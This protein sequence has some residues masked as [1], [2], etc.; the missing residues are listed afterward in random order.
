LDPQAISFVCQEENILHEEDLQKAM[1]NIR[2]HGKEVINVEKGLVFAC[3]WSEDG[4]YYRALVNN[5]N[6]NLKKVR[7]RFIDYGNQAEEGF[8]NLRLLSEEALKIPVLA[9]LINLA[10]VP[11]Q[12]LKDPQIGN[13]MEQL[14]PL[15]E[16]SL[17]VKAIEN[18]KFV[19]SHPNGSLIND[20][21][22]AK[23]KED[24]DAPIPHN[25]QGQEMGNEFNYDK[26][27]T[28][29]L[30]ANDPNTSQSA[31]VLHAESP[32]SIY[33]CPLNQVG[34]ADNVASQ[35]NAYA[36]I[37][38]KMVGYA[39]SIGKLCVVKSKEDDGWYRGACVQLC[40]DEFEIFL[41]DYGFRE[42]LPRD[43][44]KMMD[45]SLMKTVFLANHCILDGFENED[46]VDS[47][48]KLYGQA[49]KDRFPFATEV[50]IRVVKHDKDKG[51]YVIRMPKTD[52]ILPTKAKKLNDEKELKIKELEAQLAK[53][54]CH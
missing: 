32:T 10:D 29:S 37:D 22:A 28:A 14:R 51:Y 23:L 17:S 53:L 30:N 27:Y 21:I 15:F 45:P 20:L 43:R 6:V 35:V 2:T 42:V 46:L 48:Q 47:Y 39:P 18:Q 50:K 26:V 31:I 9:K 36:E 54:R 38:P 44:I 4:N 25:I 8:D 49:I 7:V 13:R 52:D 5:I 19:V 40:G 12:P 11:E 33:I 41:V 24:M 1:D 16:V 34:V 3:K